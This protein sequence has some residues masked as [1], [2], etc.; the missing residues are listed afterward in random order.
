[1][2]QT[3]HTHQNLMCIKLLAGMNSFLITIV[4]W[5]CRHL[6]EIKNNK[7]SWKYVFSFVPVIHAMWSLNPVKIFE[8]GPGFPI[9][10]RGDSQDWLIF[11]YQLTFLSTIWP[12]K[13]SIFNPLHW[14][15]S[16]DF[17]NLRITG[18]QQKKIWKELDDKYVPISV[19]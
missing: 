4:L 17:V 7:I 8:P 15:S 9:E 6:H 14:I 1:M 12:R 18:F 2:K 5:S 11:F 13:G 10:A 3:K 16:I 19:F